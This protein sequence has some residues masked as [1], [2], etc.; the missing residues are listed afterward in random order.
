MFEREREGQRDEE[1]ELPS[2]WLEE[3]E[4]PAMVMSGGE[5]SEG[6]MV[7]TVLIS[8]QLSM[9]INLTFSPLS[10]LFTF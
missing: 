1:G 9:E 3:P 5:G 8:S 4:P 6:T 7:S 2:P 10:Q